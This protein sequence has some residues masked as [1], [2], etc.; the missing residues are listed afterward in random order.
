[1]DIC[2]IILVEYSST[3]FT[4]ALGMGF[5]KMNDHDQTFDP[6]GYQQQRRRRRRRDFLGTMQQSRTAGCISLAD[7]GQQRRE[8]QVDCGLPIR[9]LAKKS[10]LNVN[11]LK[12]IENSKAS[13]GLETLQQLSFSLETPVTAFFENDSPKS[14][15]AHYKASQR[16]RIPV[17]HGMLEDLRAGLPRRGRNIP[18]NPQT[19][20]Q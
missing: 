9:C 14:K 16:T 19:P 18:G 12:I 1:M 5:P 13:S 7:V 3:C 6:S 17:I 2:T 20:F 10:G 15:I 11:T 8:I 4:I